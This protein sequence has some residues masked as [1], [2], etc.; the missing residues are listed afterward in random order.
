LIL[1]I[2]GLWNYDLRRSLAT[3]MSN[4]LNYSDA[5][6]D[7]ILGHEKTSSLGHYLHVSFDAMTEP[8]QRYADW[9]WA[10]HDP[11]AISRKPVAPPPAAPRTMQQAHAS[12]ISAPAY[13]QPPVRVP[14]RQSGMRPLSGRERQILALIADGRSHQ[15]MADYLGLSI[16]TI[17]CYRGRLLD[18][19]QLAT[20]AELIVYARE[21]ALTKVPMV[22]IKRGR[23]GSDRSQAMG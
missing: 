18:R 4:K 14:V 6:I 9:L 19:L 20:T 11:T 12:V 10:L 17:V 5:K 13:A 1:G 22:V 3:H 23:I 15:E 16:P 2:H 21:H 8:I 7:A